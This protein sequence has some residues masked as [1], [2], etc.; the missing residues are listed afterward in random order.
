MDNTQTAARVSAL[1][2]VYTPGKSGIVGADGI[3]GVVLEDVSGLVL[4]QVAGWQDSLAQVGKVAAAAA[5]VK[6]VPGPC[7]AGTGKSG[8]MLRIE[9]MK[10]WLV[11]VAAPELEPQQGATLDLSHSRTHLRVTG[12]DAAEFLNRFLPLDLRDDSFPVGSVASSVIHHV[13]VTL[14][15]S[16]QGYEMFI[17]RGF[18]LT[19]WQGFT[20]VAEQFG[21]EVK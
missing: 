14:W 6:S 19:L 5:G 15:H 21:L 4:H 3:A 10:W 8:A 11:G 2:S 20:E 1:A 13:G 17:P 18:A 16:A 9:P 12:P 7:S